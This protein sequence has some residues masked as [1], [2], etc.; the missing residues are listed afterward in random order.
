MRRGRGM[1]KIRLLLLLATVLLTSCGGGESGQGAVTSVT[2]QT[3]GSRSDLVVSQYFSAN[4]HGP[5][6]LFR[7]WSTVGLV[8]HVTVSDAANSS[9][10]TVTAHFLL[11]SGADRQTQMDCWISNQ[12]SDALCAGVQIPLE[13]AAK[14]A[15]NLYQKTGQ[16]TGLH[17]DLYDV[18]QMSLDVLPPV[19][20]FLTVPLLAI[21]LPV[22]KLIG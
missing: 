4:S 13:F 18:Y 6:Q 3:D 11:F 22:Y 21:T 10:P 12:Y 1:Q 7:V 5:T 19:I 8:L 14:V 2:L 20:D 15:I 17:G 16:E 9:G